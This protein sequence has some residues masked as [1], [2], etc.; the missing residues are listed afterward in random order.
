MRWRNVWF[1]VPGSSRWGSILR[2]NIKW[3]K[4]SPSKQFISSHFRTLHTRKCFQCDQCSLGLA[5]QYKHQ[6]EHTVHQLANRADMSKS[7]VPIRREREKL[8]RFDSL[9]NDNFVKQ[10]AEYERGTAIDSNVQYT[11]IVSGSVQRFIGLAMDATNQFQDPAKLAECR[12]SK[13]CRNLSRQKSHWYPDSGICWSDI[14]HESA[15]QNPNG[16]IIK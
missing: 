1:V 15:G 13:F 11:G 10:Y 9:P 4:D 16:H 7:P 6:Q 3:K 14:S 12:P 2:T 8:R 5:D